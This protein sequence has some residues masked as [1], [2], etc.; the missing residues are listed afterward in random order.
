MRKKSYILPIVSV[1]LLS[2]PFLFCA[3]E[4]DESFT[5]NF[6]LGYRMVDTSG[7]LYKY[8]EDINLD[9]GVRLFQ[10]NLHFTPG[11]EYKKFFDT[12]DVNVYNFGGDPFETFAL[13]IQ[14]YSRYTLKYNRTK[15]AY[16][17]HDMH[18]VG[19]RELYDLHTFDFERISDSGLFKV[20]FGKIANLYLDFNRYTKKG[21]SVTTFDINRIEFEFDKPINEESSEITVG[22]GVQL[23]RYAFVI[24][25]KILDYENTNSLFLPGYADGGQTARYPSALN[26]F[27]VNQPYDLKTYTHTFKLNASPFNSLLIAGS[28]QLSNQDMNLDYSEEASGINYLDRTFSYTTGGSGNFERKM[29]LYDFDVSFL[30]SNK[31]V[32]VG[33]VRYHN[34]D[35][36]G[37]IQPAS[38]N[39]VPESLY[40][41]G[42]SSFGFENLGFEGGLQYQFSPQFALTVGYR[43]ESRKLED[44]ETVDFEEK[45]QKNGFFGNLKF[46]MASTFSA[47]KG[48]LDYQYGSYD[49]PFSLISPTSFN[50]FKIMSDLR[51]QNAAL[52]ASYL[53]TKSKNDLDDLWESSKNELT[54]R[55]GYHMAK[56]KFSA[57]YSYINIKHEGNRIVSYPPS[58]SGP[59]GSFLW[60]ILYEGKSHLL[61]A[62]LSV[63]PTDQWK[64]GAYFNYYSNSGF[65]EISRT[66]LKA[67]A[68]YVFESGLISQV[69]YRLVDFKEKNSGF[70][71]YKANILELS[72][73][74]RWNK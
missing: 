57:G 38:I 49:N 16:F 21:N 61:D 56:A 52:T 63:H 39:I 9:D 65:W 72:L 62:S 14:K 28:I 66:T 19:G 18:E 60:E 3:E 6:L 24:E 69:G 13:S 33:A 31:F 36:E 44:I 70:N 46:Q 15:S 29:H 11:E 34:F 43:N 48:T 5:G 4:S 8:K 67:Y 42:S 1:L 50:R 30:L 45:T 68:E 71:D 2:Q 51:V 41:G 10:F 20:F 40:A 25:E 58:Y 35:Q 54:F 12:L 37:T 73:G 26:F 27:F 22:L 74:Y 59:A 47:F 17:Y 55:G 32:I 7:T 53:L 64:V 23:N